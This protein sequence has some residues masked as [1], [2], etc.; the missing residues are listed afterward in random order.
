[1]KKTY[2]IGE[3]GANHQNDRNI[4]KRLIDIIQV[5]GC[6]LVKFQKRNPNCIPEDQ[7]N[8]IRKTPW[9]TEETY[10]EYRKKLELGRDDYDWIDYYCN[11]RGI[12]WSASVWDIDSLEFMKHYQVPLLKIPSA[13]ITNLDLVEETAKHCHQE[14]MRLVISTG[15]ST[16]DEIDQAIYAASKHLDYS[17][18]VVLHCTSTYPA[19]LKEL[20]LSYVKVLRERYPFCQVGYSGHELTLGTSVA[21][22]YLGASVI[23]RHVTIDRELPGTD[24]RASLTMWGLLKLVSGIRELETAYGDGV[25]RVYPSELPIRKKLRGI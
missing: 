24:H 6:D 22:V 7:K 23:E 18:I 15:M 21:A 20:N 8:V 19:A 4:L 25:K 3:V 5:A 12:K 11:Q 17:Q 2:I 13:L 14:N 10:L 16:E 9:G 1:M